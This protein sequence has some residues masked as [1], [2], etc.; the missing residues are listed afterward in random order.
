MELANT[1]Y[2]KFLNRPEK[3]RLSTWKGRVPKYKEAQKLNPVT[4]DDLLNVHED[5]ENLKLLNDYLENDYSLIP[6]RRRGEKSAKKSNAPE[7][8]PQR[9]LL[10]LTSLCNL[11]C[12]MCPRTV[13][14]RP[15]QNMSKKN[16]YKCID[17]FD[18][19]GIQ[20][21]W[22]YNIGESM[23]HPDFAEIL[24]YAGSKKT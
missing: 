1:R 18:S 8:F 13:L 7:S 19:E 2:L 24:N 5:H 15:V 9:V 22:L 21:L 23:L 6:I 12:V 10:E 14:D 20:G 11:D 3:L 17:E 16:A 4:V